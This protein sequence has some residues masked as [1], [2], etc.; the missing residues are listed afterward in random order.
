LYVEN[1][2]GDLDYTNWGTSNRIYYVATT[3]VDNDDPQRG[4]NYFKPYRT[5]KFALEKA[6]DGYSGTTSI[7]VSTGEYQEICPMIVP[8]RTAI[9]GEELRSVSIRAAGPVA[10][11]VQDADKFL[12][13]VIHIGTK[14]E[15]IVRGLNANLSLGNN[16]SQ[17]TAGPATATEAAI[18]NSLWA[19]IISVIDYKVNDSGAMPAVTGSNTLTAGGRLVAVNI[20]ETN[21][22]LIK[23]ES[24]AWMANTYALYIY[25]LEQWS[26]DIDRL[27]NAVQYDLQY[28]GNYKSVLEAR[29]YSNKVIGSQLED[30][31]Y[32]RDT[33]GIRNMT[34]R[35]LE[36]TLP[37]ISEGDVYSITTAG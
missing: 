8:A 27:I 6:N 28:P 31:F 20:L 10:E 37:A 5:V 26:T 16:I 32:V 25:D 1:N 7:Q 21:R 24:A 2:Q 29:W 9:I 19:S 17:I 33:T 3:G 36:G 14:L 22:A 13:S 34:L 4:V 18:V 35:G 12:E 11:Y 30:M 15:N 23:A